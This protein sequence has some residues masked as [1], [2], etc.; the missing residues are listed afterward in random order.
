MFTH[1]TQ[2]WGKTGALETIE[3]QKCEARDSA[4]RHDEAKSFYRRYRAE[5]N[6]IV[7]TSVG[8]Y[9]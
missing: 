1:W 6:S 8:P 4:G 7:L 9:A 2:E 3:L 5:V